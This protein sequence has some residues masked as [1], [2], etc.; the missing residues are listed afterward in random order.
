MNTS[1][2]LALVLKPRRLAFRVR[3]SRASGAAIDSTARAGIALVHCGPQWQW[4]KTN[5]ISSNR[6]AQ[7]PAG[8]YL[9][10]KY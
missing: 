3:G 10:L 5:G 6:K 1:G 9:L 2:I 8:I 7:A 4:E